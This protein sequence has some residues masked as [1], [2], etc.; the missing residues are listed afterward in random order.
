MASGTDVL[1][2]IISGV[3]AKNIKSIANKF[4][5]RVNYGAKSKITTAQLYEEISRQA[6]RFETYINLQK[7]CNKRNCKLSICES[8]A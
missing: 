5:G 8:S 2:G 4:I 3:G 7:S 1:F 6:I